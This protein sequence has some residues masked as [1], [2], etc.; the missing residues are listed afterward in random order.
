VA[1]GCAAPK[2]PGGECSRPAL[3]W[4]PT[5]RA[6]LRPSAGTGSCQL[7]IAKQLARVMAESAGV[8]VERAFLRHC[9]PVKTGGERAKHGAAAFPVCCIFDCLVTL[10]IRLSRGKGNTK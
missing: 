7:G 8:L 5:A 4:P 3:R 6:G 10:V 1:G 2:R 9:Q